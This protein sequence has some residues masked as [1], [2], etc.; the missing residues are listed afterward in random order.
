VDGDNNDSTAACGIKDN[1]GGDLHFIEALAGYT[2]NSPT[3]AE[4]KINDYPPATTIVTF[5]P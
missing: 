1:I 3:I 4:W 2:D 5:T